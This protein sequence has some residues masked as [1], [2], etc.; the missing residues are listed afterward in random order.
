MT[1]LPP[2]SVVGST[3][4]VWLHEGWR[5]ARTPPRACAN[6]GQLARLPAEWDAAIV[7]GTVAAAV[8]EDINAA[9][10]YD[11][12]DWWYH[13]DFPADP[14]LPW[15]RAGERVGKRYYLRFEGL[16]TL[17]QV[18]LNG[19]LILTSHNMFRAYRIDVTKLLRG[20]NHLTICFQSLE[21]ALKQRRAR[22]H[23][24]TALVANQNLR[25]YRTTL[26][27]RIPG[28]TPPIT[29]V[30]PWG[31]IALEC[32]ERVDVAALSLQ[33]SAQR[34]KVCAELAVLDCKAIE[35]ARIR[36]GEELYPVR[37]SRPRQEHS[38]AGSVG[39]PV[40][41]SAD[42][43]ISAPLWWPHTHGTPDLLDCQIELR[44]GGEWLQ[45]DCG[46]I[47]FKDVSIYQEGGQVRLSVNGTPVFCRGACWTTMDFL[48]L[49]GD[50]GALRRALETARD[51][52][53]NMLRVGG[54]M[55]YESTEFYALCDELGILVW[56]DF[57]F[58]N[59]DYPVADESFRAE[60]DAEV[61]HQLERLHRHPC[62]AAYCGGSEVAQ[63]A[64]MLGLPAA[65][66]SNE[67][68]LE[69]LPRHCAELHAGIPYFPSSPW[70]GA[71][72]MH[73]SK[74]ISHYYG[75]GAYRRPLAD[76][77]TAR[78]KF[79]T[80]CLGFSNVPDAETMALML[81]GTMPPPHHPRWKA[82]VPRD[83]GSGYDFEDVRDHYL[84]ALFGEDPAELRSQD[85]ERYYALS[86]VVSGEV[87]RRVF[88]EWRAPHSQCGGALV[89]F[90][91]DLWPGA[92]WGITDSTGRAKAALWYLKRAWAPRS[93]HLTDE[94]LDGLGIHATN[95]NATP[96]DALIELEMYQNGRK[97]TASA[98][99]SM[100]IPARGAVSL[101][102]D[103]MLGY[104]SDSTNAYRFGPPKHDVIAVRLMRADT[105]EQLSEDFHFPAG[106]DLRV[107][108]DVDLKAEA[109]WRDDG[110][111][112]VTLRSNAFLQAMNVSC[113]AFT[114]DDNYF[115]LAPEQEKT[116]LFS[117]SHP[118]EGHKS[119]K[120]HFE[121][122]NWTDT[123]VV[124][125]QKP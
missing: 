89:W 124:R 80:E 84:K 34:L 73:V 70:G 98:Q 18:W 27:G 77:K 49:R 88:A 79:A 72:P 32:V 22:P 81:D 42:L 85:I 23:W 8:H 28:W 58:A 100:T 3:P 112:A 59:M 123:L 36:V 109:Q 120:A 57:M 82:R 67:F 116:L 107:Q 94:G 30:G 1:T 2:G 45:I 113:D 69:A 71:L 29:P 110:K 53:V 93:I 97:A 4:T 104:F 95:E 56:Q 119:L 60:V 31:P 75:I 11:A 90:Y 92:G 114:P 44:I 6:P 125:A 54:T 62:I 61:R 39:N 38:G 25:W 115:H 43:P 16:A 20:E 103:A 96:L 121:A 118:G 24:K 51:A 76:A 83:N 64:A 108:R 12:D 106:M 105:G 40:T 26:L 14:P 47:G 9:G 66:W 48:T 101:Q 19:T 86:R 13:L 17:A 50:R 46:R 35:E 78:V 37:H 52:G 33:T 63:Q 41:L 122:L 111:V 68:F 65:Q 91:R 99:A 55:T 5:L 10:N 74:G 117:P 15:E 21:E 102:G 87:M 7:P